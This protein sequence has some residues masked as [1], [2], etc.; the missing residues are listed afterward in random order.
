LRL[1]PELGMKKPILRGMKSAFPAVLALA[2]LACAPQESLNPLCTNDE[3][4]ADP[5]LIGEWR[6]VDGDSLIEIRGD[7]R[8]KSANDS[9]A[10]TNPSPNVSPE[11][12]RYSILYV[13]GKNK[14]VS[15]FDG[16]LIRLG[17]DLFLDVTPDEAPVDADFRYFPLVRTEDGNPPSFTKLSEFLYMAL[18]PS[19][20]KDESAAPGDSYRLQIIAVHAILKV[21]FDDD[22][23]RVAWLDREWTKDM[24]HDGRISIDHEEVGDTLLLTARPESLQD[25]VQQF[26]N[27]PQAFKEIGAWRRKR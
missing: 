19:Q 2:A 16:R 21:R 23:L 14:K 15:R 8:G 3:A 6:E 27:D 18:V 1:K 22:V 12:R 17:D 26:S 5:A 4:I 25:S 9:D 24:I 13:E 7:W 11:F 10:D 20:S